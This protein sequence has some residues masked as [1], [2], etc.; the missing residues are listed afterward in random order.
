MATLRRP[1]K[2]KTESVPGAVGTSSQRSKSRPASTTSTA[3]SAS[4]ASGTSTKPRRTGSDRSTSKRSSDN[5][6]TAQQYDQMIAEGMSEAAWQGQLEQYAKSLG[7]L[8]Y[9]T[10]DSRGSQRGFPDLTMIKPGQMV[11]AELK[12]QKGSQA[13]LTFEQV[14]WLDALARLHDS[15][16]YGVEVYGAVRPLDRDAFLLSLQ[17]YEERDGALHQWCLR[18]TCERCNAER[19]HAKLSTSV[20]KKRARRT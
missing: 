3:T 6:V 10:H 9:H 16:N 8:T 19:S 17:G 2:R 4:K 18:P 12:R 15:G 7:Y 13:V 14:A 5:T 1:G 11:L 20:P